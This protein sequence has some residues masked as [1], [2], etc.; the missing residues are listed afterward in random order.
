MIVN[1]S[2]IYYFFCSY[3]IGIGYSMTEVNAEL[4][5]TYNVMPKGFLRRLSFKE[6]G[7]LRTLM[8]RIVEIS[9]PSKA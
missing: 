7:F 9:F 4:N 8:E 6:W 3:H 5:Q 2:E 1:L